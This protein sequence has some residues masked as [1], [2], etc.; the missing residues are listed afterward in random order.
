M[1]NV[2]CLHV[3]RQ[4]ITED[5]PGPAIQGGINVFIDENK[6]YNYEYFLVQHQLSG[7]K[8]SPRKEVIRRSYFAVRA[9]GC[10][11]RFSRAQ[12]SGSRNKDSEI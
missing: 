9:T 10:I 11:R 12:I 8:L 2:Q 7:E 6:Y 5:Q 4:E 3:L 1:V